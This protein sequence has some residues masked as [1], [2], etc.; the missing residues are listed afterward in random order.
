MRSIPGN[1]T[2][3]NIR[4]K[5]PRMW[6]LMEALHEARTVDRQQLVSKIFNDHPKE[7]DTYLATGIIRYI[8]ALVFSGQCLSFYP[9][10]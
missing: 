2:Y 1:Y 10:F 7:L 3:I 6:K 8:F 9:P 5:N 4:V